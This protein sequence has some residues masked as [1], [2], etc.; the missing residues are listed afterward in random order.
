MISMGA[1][2]LTKKPIFHR[3]GEVANEGSQSLREHEEYG[4]REPPRSAFGL[5]RQ[6]LWHSD[7]KFKPLA[8]GPIKG[9]SETASSLPRTCIPSSASRFRYRGSAVLRASATYC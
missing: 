1:F 4:P 8:L 6:R 9:S 7:L 2:W 3:G 5:H